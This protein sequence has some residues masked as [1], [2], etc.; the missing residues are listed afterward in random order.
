MFYKDDAGEV[1]HTYSTFGRGVEV[2]MGA[3]AM[4]DLT[5]VGRGEHDGVYKMDWVR[6]HDRYEQAPAAAA[7]SSACCHAD[8]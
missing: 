4:L 3:Y 2:M 7:T 8:A 1:F 6:H 5:P